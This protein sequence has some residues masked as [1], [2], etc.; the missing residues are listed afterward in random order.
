MS[1]RIEK[2][3]EIEQ[4]IKQILFNQPDI[5]KDYSKSFG[6]KT[7]NTKK[8]YICHVINFCSY[9]KREY[10]IDVNDI[11]QLQK[12]NY[13][14]INAYM[15]YTK[16]YDPNGNYINKEAGTCAFEFYAIKHF[17]KFLMLSKYIQNN[18]CLD[19][20]IPKDK[21]KHDIISLEPEEIKIIKNNILK[22][23]GSHKAKAYQEKWKTRDLCIVMLGIT[24]GLRVSAITNID[25]DDINFKEKTLNTIEKGNFERTIYLSDKLIEIIQLWIKDRNKILNGI[26]CNALF[27]SSRKQRI[28]VTTIRSL[29]D[30]YAYNIHKKI[31]P[32]KLRSTCATNLYDKTGD[33][34]LVADVLG[35]NNIQNTKRYAKVS[36]NKRKMAAQ[37]LSKL[38]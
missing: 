9:L 17:C 15:D 37:E 8:A 4:K 27:I 36:N 18:P 26:N 20:E 31:T 32:H 2:E 35:H 25:L 6:N 28:A 30:K 3:K 34:Y 7:F 23:V 1:G 13:S 5:I 14:H 16:H 11:Q 29:M 10:Q 21:K 12:I 22:G 38:I 33:I 24:T 19:V